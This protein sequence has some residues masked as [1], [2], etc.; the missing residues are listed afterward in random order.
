[1]ELTEMA[2]L[3]EARGLKKRFARFEL[4]GV[5]LVLPAGCILGLI[6]ENGAGKSTTTGLLLGLLRRDGGEVR[7]LGEDPERAEPELHEE[8]GVVLDS[9]P[10]AETMS[11][12]D[13]KRI[14][15]AGYASFDGA[16]FDS[17][18]GR[19]GLDARQKI[20]EYSRGMRMKLSIAAALSHA[21]RLLI[22]DEPTSGLDPIVRDELLDILLEFIQDERR[23]VLISSHIL[24]DLEKACDYIS[25]I[26][27]G[28][29]VF[30]EEKDVLLDKY[31]L[32]KGSEGEIAALDPARVVGVRHGQFGCE[33]L[34]ERGYAGKLVCDRA[35]I[36]DI[37]LFY[38]RGDA[39]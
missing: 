33:A 39:K 1:M 28:R 17:L 38:I 24:S 3:I 13:V 26:H 8:I 7:V 15:A 16:R 29:T 22:L 27:A 5:D 25:F 9:C 23:S 18:C 34:V 37:M 4:G 20:R 35:G 12:R 30:T 32:A 36:E 6:G 11:C 21:S 14:L 19:F 2:N 31:V 10:F